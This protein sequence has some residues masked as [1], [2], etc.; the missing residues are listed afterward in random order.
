MKKSIK[1]I[2]LILLGVIIL[3]MNSCIDQLDV[4]PAGFIE[5][6]DIFEDNDKTAAFLNTCY[7]NIPW[8]GRDQNYHTRG[9]VDFS[10]EGW[11]TSGFQSTLPWSLPQLVYDGVE[12]HRPQM[13]WQVNA[14]GGTTPFWDA[15]YS[16]I[17]N[18]N[19]F[20]SR[21]D[22]AKVNNESDRARWKAEAYVLRAWYHAILLQWYSMPL[23]ISDK[24][25]AFDDDFSSIERSSPYE[26]AQFIVDD[27]NKALSFNELPWRITTEAEAG[28]MTKA[29]AEAIKSRMVIYAASPL[30]NDGNDYWEWAYN[31]NKSSLQNLKNNGYE[32][33][34]KVNFPATYLEQEAWFLPLEIESLSDD[35]WNVWYHAAVYNEYF[36]QVMTYEANPIDK[37]TIYQSRQNQGRT[38]SLE[39]CGQAE[40]V[41]L[42]PSQELVDAFETYD[43]IPIID[44]SNPYLDEQHREPNLNS[45]NALYDEQNP[46]V[47][48][49]ARFY[50]SIY[51]NLAKRTAFFAF[52]ETSASVE[53]Y[54]AASGYRTRILTTYVNEPRSGISLT[55]SRN[56]VTG[57]YGRKFHHPNSGSNNRVTGANWKYFRLGEVILNFAEAAAEFGA[58]EEARNAVNDI[59]ERV[60]LPGLPS[61]LSK[62]ELI[63][64]I[65]NERRVELSW[66]EHRYYDVRR[67]QQ[68]DG[69][70]SKTDKWVGAIWWTRQSDGTFTF[71][72]RPVRENPRG[73]WENKWLKAP[74]LLDEASRIVSITGEDWQN[75]GW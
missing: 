46:Y 5:L 14:H 71:E 64:R 16:A 49:E 61:G 51:Y 41:G 65:R 57:Y 62:Q 27:C 2:I 26:V 11:S 20:L 17:H 54:P 47:N 32:L 55:S 50:A 21:I 69:D 59:R 58:L 35:Q 12:L 56:T 53:N 7:N 40:R 60:G 23:P 43:G 67:W 37:E 24:P 9:V 28:R 36:Q 15:C 31:I 3:I 74:L 39:S 38:W 72:R 19:T 45:Q 10:D 34:D 73:C 29:V 70:L 30:Y 13:W 44:Y 66:E 22:D 75:P 8:G 1:N 68:P 18:L 4:A 52:N 63:L 42:C 6:D 48:R 33:Y 25:Y